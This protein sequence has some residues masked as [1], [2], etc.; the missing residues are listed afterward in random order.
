MPKPL[1]FSVP[2]L[3]SEGQL[4]TLNTLPALPM[5]CWDGH[6]KGTSIRI[7]RYVKEYR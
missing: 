4:V 2:I 7:L 6:N 5:V 1:N 3:V